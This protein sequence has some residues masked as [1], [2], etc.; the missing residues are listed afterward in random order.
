MNTKYIELIDRLTTAA[1]A[2]GFEDDVV[3]VARDYCKDFAPTRENSL[4]NL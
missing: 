1:G 2:S 4:R 3:N